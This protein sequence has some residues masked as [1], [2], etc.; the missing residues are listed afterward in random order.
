MGILKTIMMNKLANT[1]DL[2]TIEKYLK[3]INNINSDLI[4]S[5]YLLKYKL[6]LKII[7]L[8]YMT[9]QG[10]ITLD[11]IKD[12]FKKLHLFNNISLASKP[13]IIKASPKSD[14]AVVWVDIWDSQSGFMAKNIINW[15]FN[16]SQYIATICSMNMNLEVPQYK[17]C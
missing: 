1:S 10:I 16:I 4:K 13:H 8:P 17:N 5:P 6:Y 15:Q 2:T 14:M 7:G 11:I 3:N 12:V 9:E